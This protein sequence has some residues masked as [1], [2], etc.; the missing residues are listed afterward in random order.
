MAI[1]DKREFMWA[2]KAFQSFELW[3]AL[4][5][6]NSLLK[7][8]CVWMD[9]SVQSP[10]VWGIQPCPHNHVNLCSMQIII[11]CVIISA[12]FIITTFQFTGQVRK[13]YRYKESKSLSDKECSRGH[14]A[15]EHASCLGRPS[16]TIQFWSVR[17]QFEAHQGKV[18]FFTHQLFNHFV[19]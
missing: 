10:S 19:G 12:L 13:S 5:W 16:D 3:K 7:K 11:L 17:R 18:C 2:I 4:L 14:G 6:H 15:I 1:S 8:Y 9:D